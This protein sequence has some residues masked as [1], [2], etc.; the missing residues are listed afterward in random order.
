MA[1]PTHWRTLR[2][3]TVFASGPVHEVAVEVVQLPDGRIVPDYHVI[4][5]PDYAL[6]YAQMQD[7]TVPMI[8]QYK[9]GA[10]LVCLTFPGGAIADGEAPLDAARRELLEETGCAATDWLSLGAFVTNANQGCNTAHLFRAT[11]CYRVSDPCSGDL[12][13]MSLLYLDPVSLLKR[14]ALDEIGL[15]AHV[16]LLLLATRSPESLDR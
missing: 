11:G 2:R 4:R 5:L 3:E 10:R 6:V 9:H 14:T 13:E 15:A 12:E 7:G 1:D 16:A 8:R